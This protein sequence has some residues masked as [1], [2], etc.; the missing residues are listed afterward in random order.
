MKHYRSCQFTYLTLSVNV[1]PTRGETGSLDI[2]ES[3]AHVGSMA[4]I[5]TIQKYSWLSVSWAHGRIASPGPPVVA[6]GCAMCPG[7]LAVSGSEGCHF[8]ARATNCH[9]KTLHSTLSLCHGDQNFINVLS[10]WVLE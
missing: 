3:L 1:H 4:V 7:Q 2:I 10:V 9:Y 8:W 5:S 6:L